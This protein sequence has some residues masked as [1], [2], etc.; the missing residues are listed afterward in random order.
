VVTE[1]TEESPG[2]RK[3]RKELLS[4]W[5]RHEV[6]EAARRIFAHLGYAAANVDEIAR[7]AGIAKGTIYLYFKSKEE[8]FAAALEHDLECLTAKTV[9]GMSAVETFSERLTVFLNMRV[10]YLRHSQDFLRVYFEE[11]GSRSSRSP[12]IAEVIDK[13]FWRGIAAM[14]KCVEEAIANNEIR[15]VPVEHA[16]FAIYDIAKGFSERHLRG[17][18]SLSLEE[19]AAFTHSLILNGLQTDQFPNTCPSALKES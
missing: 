1:L 6:L 17:W 7:E 18:A 3:T 8:I 14:R 11:F 13:R 12:Q 9:E 4:E 2:P 5:R 10:A 16:A 15:D 19:D